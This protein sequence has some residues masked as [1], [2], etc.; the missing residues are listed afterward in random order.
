M[1]TGYVPALSGFVPNELQTE[2][3]RFWMLALYS[4]FPLV[5][6]VIGALLFGMFSL[7]EDEHR[8]I[9]RELD[10]RALGGSE[11]LNREIPRETR[12]DAP[13]SEWRPGSASRREP[14]CIGEQHSQ[15][16]SHEALDLPSLT[17]GEL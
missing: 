2:Q 9:R 8:R 6:Y 10:R 11:S 3:A 13:S 4:L 1:L 17:P 12:T 14:S 16:R 7:D 5:C 15:C